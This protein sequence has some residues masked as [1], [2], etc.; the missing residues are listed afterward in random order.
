MDGTTLA[1]AMR[2]AR[3][4]LQERYE[5]ESIPGFVVAVSH[6]GT[7]VL[8]EAHGH[9]D[10][11]RHL[12]MTAGHVFRIA[13]HSKTFTATTVMQLAEAGRL[14]IDDPAAN[15]LPWLKGHSDGRWA[16]VTLRQLLSHGG[17]VV[18][19][20]LQSNFW[21]LERPFP[22]AEGFTAEMRETD[23]VLD[24][25]VKMKYSNFGYALLGLVVEAVAG[26]PYNQVV[27]DRIVAPL[28]LRHTHPDYRPELLPELATGYSRREGGLR[29]PI[30][31]VGT[32]A[33]SAATG[34][35]STA[36]DLCAYF[37][38]Q[39]I[40]SGKLLSDEAKKEMQRAAWPVLAPGQAS[41]ADY[42]L[43]FDLRR[44]EDRE[45][46]GHGGGF[47]GFITRT[48]AD[49]QGSLV[50]AALTNAVDG[51]AEAIA[52]GIHRIIRYFDQHAP[53]AGARD[54]SA[55]DGRYATLWGTTSVIAA[56]G[57]LV[58]VTSAGWDP[59]AAA[60]KLE[61]VEDHTF[62]I[63]ECASGASEGELV[64]FHPENGTL[65]RSG[66]TSWP[67]DDWRRMLAGRTRISL[68]AP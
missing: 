58:T 49:P 8:A 12:P 21:H 17:G 65:S 25:N 13:S 14:R 22:D 26:Q 37:T 39:M 27:L 30:E 41:K 1:R 61:W 9:A 36:E 53:A 31:H 42:G 48:L 18:R 19:D 15:Y 29:L 46:F 2:F 44:N 66:T 10:L 59:L 6:Q 20:G 7:V 68:Q 54:W 33:L 28:N 5:V 51:P 38:A 40:G 55:L 16:H 47:P 64:R 4:W 62:R 50:V 35:C 11:E 32:G 52:L 45:T 60:N 3:A 57:G 23:L 63:T 43:G 56:D 34:F 67:V 24:N